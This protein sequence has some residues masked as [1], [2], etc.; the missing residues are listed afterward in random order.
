MNDPS[1][2]NDFMQVTFASDKRSL[3]LLKLENTGA[4]LSHCV[5][6]MNSKYEAYNITGLK[7]IHKIFNAF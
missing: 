1:V 5:S 3:S 6:L 2:V 7:S 4:V